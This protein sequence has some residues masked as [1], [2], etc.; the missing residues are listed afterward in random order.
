MKST[1]ECGAIVFAS[2]S[3][4]I[5]IHI[6]EFSVYSQTKILV[7]VYNRSLMICSLIAE[8]NTNK[9]SKWPGPRKYLDLKN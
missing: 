4:G 5:V 3:F 9:S 7:F 2:V 1:I 8:P 6:L